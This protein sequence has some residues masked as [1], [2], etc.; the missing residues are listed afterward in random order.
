MKRRQKL[1]AGVPAIREDGTPPTWWLQQPAGVPAVQSSTD[2]PVCD[3]I[4]FLRY[5]LRQA[6][7]SENANY[8]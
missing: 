7:S 5:G 3:F 8:F 1:P 2:I 6:Q 4:R